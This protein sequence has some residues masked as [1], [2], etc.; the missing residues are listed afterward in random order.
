[1]SR[2]TWADLLVEDIT[3]EQ[4]SRC[5]APWAGVVS[6][7]VSPLFVNMFGFQFLRRPEG[8]IEMLDVFTGQLQ[9]MADSHD[10]FVREVNQQWWQEVY[11]FSELVYQLHEAD[12]VPGPGQ[13]YALCP[14]PALGGPNPRNGEVV[15]SR[16][17]MV[18]D[19]YVWQSL[20]AQ[21]L[22]VGHH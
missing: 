3:P 20:C 1:M 9:R 18:V 12:K 10:E 22:G 5:L 16:F 2:L 4:F 13:C 17:V 6:G 8:H 11:L 14:H 7:R 21:S 15:D 19:I